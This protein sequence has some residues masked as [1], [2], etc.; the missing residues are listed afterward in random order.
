MIALIL[1]LC[2]NGRLKKIEEMI[3]IIV[4]KNEDEDENKD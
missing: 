4:A 1:L 3:R 2:I